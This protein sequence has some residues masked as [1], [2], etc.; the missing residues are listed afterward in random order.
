MVAC[1]VPFVGLFAFMATQQRRRQARAM[2]AFATVL[3]GGRVKEGK[4]FGRWKGTDVSERFFGRLNPPVF[5]TGLTAI[6]KKSPF[7]ALLL[8]RSASETAPVMDDAPELQRR[9]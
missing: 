6:R 1:A 2:R 7:A 4:A 3:D 9:F 8:P 5:L